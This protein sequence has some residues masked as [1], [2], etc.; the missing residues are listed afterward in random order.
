MTQLKT[1]PT[2]R[3]VKQFVDSVT[4]ER[5]REDCRAVMKLMT[6]LTGKRPKLWGSS[7][8]GYGSYTYVNTTKKP[9][10]WPLV[11]VSP[12]KQ[13]L[14][15]YIMPGFSD[16]GPL[17]EKLGKHRT[18]KSCLYIKRLEDIHLPTLKQLIKRSI[19]DMKRRYEVD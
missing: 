18:G 11:A 19:A 8:I 15:V 16:Y 6:E 17:L 12:R 5:R 9:A 13:D 7:L 4:N 1:R 2:T 3:S 14:T 10:Q